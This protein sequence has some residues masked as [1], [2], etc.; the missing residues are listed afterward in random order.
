MQYP[1]ALL[2]IRTTRIVTLEYLVDADCQLSRTYLP[3][4]RTRREVRGTHSESVVLQSP[5]RMT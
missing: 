4:G 5:S 1:Q 3:S 2:F